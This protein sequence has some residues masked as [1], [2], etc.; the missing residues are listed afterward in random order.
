MNI[1]PQ[2][3]TLQITRILSVE[4][5]ELLYHLMYK[6]IDFVLAYACTVEDA[7]A[8]KEQKVTAQN[9]TA[10]YASHNDTT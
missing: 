9:C 7:I 2:Q 6:T 10:R 8:W 4:F 3:F 1:F 5:V